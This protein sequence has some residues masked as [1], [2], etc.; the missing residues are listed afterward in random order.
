[1]RKNY[2]KKY[3]LLLTFVLMSFM[4][5]AQS[6]GVTGKV[7]DE[8]NQPLVGV[9]VSVD[10]TTIGAS[11]DVNGNYTIH[12]NAGT[13]TVTAKFIGYISL[14]QTVTVQNSVV[15]VNFALQP[16]NT[17]LNEVVVIGYGTVKN[18]DLTGSVATVTSKDFDQ[19]S[20]T[21]PEQL[22]QGKVAGV[23]VTSNSGAP[24][25]GST[26]TIRGGAS[27]SGGNDPL[28][29]LDGVPLAP[30]GIAGA[31]NPLDL[32]NPNDIESFNILKDASAAAIYG[33]RAS[34]G[35]IIINTKKGQ[36]GK[37][38]LNFSSQ[39]TDGTLPSEAPVL[40]PAQFR[41]FVNT[42]GDAAQIAQLGTANT[43]WQKQIYQ[44]AI[45]TD[46]NLSLSGKGGSTSY[47]VA[48][49]H[50][51]NEGILKTTSLQRTTLSVNV[52]PSLL[53]DHLKINFNFKDAQ[54]NQRFANEGG[55]I[56]DA[57]QF[58]PTV[59]VKSTDP[60]FAP[61]GG[62]WAWTDSTSQNGL[63][64]LAPIN[65]VALLEQNNNRSSVNRVIAS[66][67]IDYRL[68][69]FPD[70]HANVNMS[71]DRSHG[72]GY[73]YIPANAAS[74]YEDYKDPNTGNLLSGSQSAYNQVE[75]NE[76]FEGYLSYTKNVKSIKSN[77]NVIAGYAIQDFTNTNYYNFYSQGGLYYTNTFS[78]GEINPL[79]V[80]NYPYYTNENIMTSLYGRFI[81]NYDEKYY[82]TASVRDDNSTKFAPATRT[83]IF[84]SAALAWRI[85]NEDFLKGGNVLSNLKLRLEY[86]VTGNQEGVQD[87]DYLAQY[88]LSNSSA[89]Y[90]FGNTYYQL[91][92]PGA[93]FPGR[94]WETT[95]STNVGLDYGFFNERLTGTVDYFYNLTSHLLAT[96]EQPAGANFS[97]QIV[98]NVGN[99]ESD[100][101]EFA[102]AAKI[103][104]QKDITWNVNFNI[105][106]NHNKITNLTAI[107][108]PAFAGIAVGGISG[109]TG[110]YIEVDQPGYARGTFL[111][112]QQVYGSNGKPLDGV[113]VDQNG[114][115]VI[116]NQDLKHEESPDPKQTMGIASD[117]WFHKWNI[118]FSGRAELG[119]YVY[120]N[121]A[122]ATGISRNILNPLGILNNGSSDV[123][124]SGLTGNGALDLLSDYYI[125]NGSFFRMD[126]M[127]IGYDF[128]H[129]IEGAGNLKVTFNV[130]NVFIITNYKGVDPEFTYTAITGAGIDNNSYPRPRTYTLGLN[131]SVQ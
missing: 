122:S 56:S 104:N 110:N 126:N 83:G 4:A 115:G 34:N 32:I 113:F 117:F 70:L 86:G 121:V 94:T 36:S 41:S 69:F 80:Y 61:Y 109:G 128:G 125:Q 43:D 120:N 92:R 82:L 52:S 68:H 53:N 108:N 77:F 38:V 81:Y 100:G 129:I 72:T 57:V 24:G 96:I 131:L 8:T 18:K 65:P 6:G 19:G 111:A 10:G 2:S 59:P 25:A 76:L 79:P 112:Y 49:G 93:Y 73:D 63:K 90:A 14:K 89:R 21:T 102:I 85:S 13:Y 103:I 30:D 33:N 37:P 55:V 88:S 99:M 101:L 106:F 28:I 114:D 54:V 58:N 84:P 20:I 23:N 1:M 71:Y 5:F 9:A 31:A 95:H 46:N 47:R 123:L 78:N 107:T 48:L 64:S 75:T 119:N 67:A 11:T 7:V 130:N 26:I 22:I 87:Y 27:I 29:V 50:T 40:S 44:N 118:G 66:L 62:Y 45:S 98:G 91:Y 35:V 17:A 16:Q 124:T 60:R 15:T 3:A 74:N 116:N 12:L 39:V 51:D 127:H 105:S 42:Y 97:N